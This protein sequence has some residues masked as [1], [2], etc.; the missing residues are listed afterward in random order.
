MPRRHSTTAL[1]S[2]TALCGLTALALL[3][4]VSTAV[5]EDAWETFVSENGH[6]SVALPTQPSQQHKEKWFPISSF[7]STVYKSIVGNEVFGV[8]HTDIP[9]FAMAF[10]S[11]DRVFQSSRK[12]FLEDSQAT[13]VSYREIELLGRPGRELIYDIPPLGGRPAQRGTAKMFFQGNRLYI[14][15]AEVTQAIP[16]GDVQRFFDSILIQEPPKDG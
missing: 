5:A 3:I 16:A 2:V 4:L 6:F 15:Y 12:G 14:F 13:E 1:G 7:V 9:G 8:N 10:A 11:N